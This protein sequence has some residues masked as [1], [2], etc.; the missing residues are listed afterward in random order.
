MVDRSLQAEG[1]ARREQILQ[2]IEEYI[3]E[4]GWAPSGSEIAQAV[5]VS[6][7]AVSKHL[8]RLEAEGRVARSGRL[9]R[10]LTIR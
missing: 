5:G 8:R 1:K 7:T 4:K 2:F 3:K 9:S 6:A 10:G